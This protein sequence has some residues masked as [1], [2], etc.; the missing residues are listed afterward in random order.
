MG[1]HH[2][3]YVFF[4]HNGR[5]EQLVFDHS[6]LF[7]SQAARLVLQFLSFI[8]KWDMKRYKLA[9]TMTVEDWSCLAKTLL[10]CIPLDGYYHMVHELSDRETLCTDP[11]KVEADTNNGISVLDLRILDHPKYAFMSIGF[12]ECLEARATDDPPVCPDVPMQPLEEGE[13]LEHD[14]TFQP[15]IGHPLS[16]SNYLD[17]HYPPGHHVWSGRYLDQPTRTKLLMEATA[18][19]AAF[20]KYETLNKAECTELFPGLYN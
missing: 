18:L 19:K 13:T 14:N 7:G 6:W 20:A 8:D 12:L 16:C 3:V 1:Q 10:I 11:R 9:D 17:L 15:L 2:Q 4:M 5:L